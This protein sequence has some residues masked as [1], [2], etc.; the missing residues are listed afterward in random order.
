MKITQ[1]DVYTKNWNPIW[2][3][4]VYDSS[5]LNATIYNIISTLDSKIKRDI[6]VGATNI[7]NGTLD[8]FNQT[9][10]NSVDS[11][12]DILMAS[13]AIPIYFPPRFFNGKYYMDGGL[14][15]NELIYPA[16]RH[17][18]QQGLNNIEIDVI[19]CSQPIRELSSKEIS[20]D[21]IFK[22]GYRTYEIASNA[23]FNHELYSNCDNTKR[24]FTRAYPMYVY[25]PDDIFPGGLLDFN[26]DKLV[27]T[28]IMGYNTTNPIKTQWCH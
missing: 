7:N 14:F 17:C 16:V 20:N 11:I 15:T 10:M 2:S 12:T 19:R 9:S 26:H 13:T 5:P 27:K 24:K 3:R 28:Y 21:N 23:L 22:L 8:L 1:D 25:K 6:I 4:S 18:R